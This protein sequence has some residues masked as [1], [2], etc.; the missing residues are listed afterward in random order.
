MNQTMFDVP[1]PFDVR[2][3]CSPHI[4]SFVIILASLILGILCVTGLFF[5]CAQNTQ[6]IPPL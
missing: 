6:M 2:V 1:D 5:P 4:S 3:R